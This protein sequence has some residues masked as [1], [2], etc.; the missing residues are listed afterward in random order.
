VS[1]NYD[2]AAKRLALAFWLAFSLLVLGI[3]AAPLYVL[4][5]TLLSRTDLLILLPVLFLYAAWMWLRFACG[6][7]K[8]LKGLPP[9]QQRFPQ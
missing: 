7:G 2:P 9:D 1:K 5:A 4:R 6:V 3:M 8:R